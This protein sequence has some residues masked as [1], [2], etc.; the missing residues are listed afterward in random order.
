VAAGG[1]GNRPNCPPG[2]DGVVYI[3]SEINTK[4]NQKVGEYVGQAKDWDRYTDRKKEHRR[5]LASVKPGNR[6]DFSELEICVDP[7]NLSLKEE[8]WIRYGGGPG[9]LQNKRHQMNDKKYHQGG[10]TVPKQ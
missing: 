3:R 5:D 9:Q 10:G 8:D 7:S 6:Y 4:T 1:K 2:Q